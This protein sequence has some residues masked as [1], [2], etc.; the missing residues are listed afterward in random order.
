[1]TSDIR[2]IQRVISEE[3][4]ALQAFQSRL[5]E[6]PLANSLQ[7][8]CELL[9][10]ATTILVSGVGKSGLI[11]QKIAAT[12]TSTGSR[13]L[14]LHPT[15]ALHGDIGIARSGDV[16]IMIS[17]SGSTAELLSLVPTL[18]K[19]EIPI[20]IL[21]GV[22]DSPLAH[23]ANIALD[24]SVLHEACPLGLAPT[25]STTLTL[26]F[27][28]AL[29]AA[30]IHRRK[31]TSEQFAEVH[32]AGQLGKNLTMCVRD[33]MHSGDQAPQV[34]EG[35]GFREILAEI[36][37]KGLGCVAVVSKVGRLS[38]FI[39][40]GDIRRCLQLSENL[41]ML[42]T[43]DLMTANPIVTH[44][45]TLLGT[46]LTQMEKRAKQLSVLPVVDE[47]LYY[48]GVIRIHDIIRAEL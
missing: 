47:Q 5:Q 4:I 37:N 3:I 13:A 38:G 40:D 32:A 12:L 24:V 8:A 15:E 23:L 33:V 34:L 26:A 41:D 19:L 9:F 39:T 44:P 31:F 16:C 25:S 1:M 17:K 20:I 45:E 28:D 48:I 14:F 18:K 43:Q 10:Q 46:A 36:T 42:F 29:A 27:G 30:M 6:Q 35:S 7:T 11:G 21:V 22:L 2:E